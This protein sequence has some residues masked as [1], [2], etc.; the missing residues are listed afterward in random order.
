MCPLWP[1]HYLLMYILLLGPMWFLSFRV[2]GAAANAVGTW[3]V[4][5]NPSPVNINANE[6]KPVTVNE[7]FLLSVTH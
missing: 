1:A 6:I 7:L 4:K 5:F 2:V 3:D